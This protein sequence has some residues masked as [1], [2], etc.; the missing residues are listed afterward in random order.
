MDRAPSAIA[1][2]SRPEFIEPVLRSWG[3]L[4]PH[5]AVLDRIAIGLLFLTAVLG[6]G[7]LGGENPWLGALV[8]VA[9]AVLAGGIGITLLTLR[10][11]YH[12]AAL[13]AETAVTKHLS[14]LRA[15]GLVQAERVG[16]FVR[17]TLD[18]AAVGTLGADLLE[19]LRR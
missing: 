13:L 6:R 10:R 2:K 15:A 18:S 8:T 16:H 4:C 7:M 11:L 3:R 17:Y 12:D 5:V 14:V 19:V 1:R 9:W